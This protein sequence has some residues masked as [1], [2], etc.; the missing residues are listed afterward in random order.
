MKFTLL[1]GDTQERAKIVSGSAT[2]ITLILSP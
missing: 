1:C 2:Q